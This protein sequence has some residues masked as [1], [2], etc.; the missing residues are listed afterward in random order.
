MTGAPMPDGADAIVMVEVT[1]AEGDDVVIEQAAEAGDHI[2]PAGGDLEAGRRGVRR[3]HGAHARA[4]RCAREPR[5]RGGAVPSA[6]A[7]RRDVDRRRARRGRAARAR[8]HPR[9]EPADAARGRRGGGLRTR[10][11][12]IARDD[13]ARA[14]DTHRGRGRRVRR[15]AHERRGV[16]GRLRL[17]EGRARSGSP[18]RAARSRGR[19]SRSSRPSRSR[20]ALVGAR[21]G[22][23]AAR[24]PGVVAGQLR[25][26]RPARAAPDDGPDRLRSRP[27]CGRPPRTA[28]ARRPDGKL[29][30]DRVRVAVEDGRYVCERAGF[31]ASNV[32]SGMAAAN[33]LA[34][35]PDGDGVAA[36]EAVEVL[37]LG[38]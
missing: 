37:L 26:V 6:A 9:L 27:R 36:G 22:V 38:L 30:L 29:H 18:E 35:I 7:R 16:D 31:Q 14:R 28:F 11:L 8:A 33:G 5:R 13:E 3:G 25:A 20:S 24:Q 32:L 19:R 10:R 17:R 2:R 4:P 12:G 15:A 1:R 23:R 21:A 34:L